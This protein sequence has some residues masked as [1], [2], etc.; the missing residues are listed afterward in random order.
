MKIV[1]TK[2]ALG[3]FKTHLIAGWKFTRK[4]IKAV[5]KKPYF[6]EEDTE[7]GERGVRIA[8]GRWDHEHDLRVIYKEENDIITI[9]TFYPTEKGRY[10]K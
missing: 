7:R 8:L 5:I 1:F 9:V 10:S 2:H 4:D 3:K 6:S